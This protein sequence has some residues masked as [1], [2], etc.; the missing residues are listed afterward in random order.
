VLKNGLFGRYVKNTWKVL[1]RGA[2]EGWKR[3]VG[4]LIRKLKKYYTESRRKGMSYMQFV[5]TAF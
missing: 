3:S 1:N 4:P 2:G 5:G